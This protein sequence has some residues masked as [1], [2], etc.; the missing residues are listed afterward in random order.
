MSQ[1]CAS[2]TVASGQKCSICSVGPAVLT[3]P[4]GLTWCQK[5]LDR[6][7]PPVGALNA[8][9]GPSAPSETTKADKEALDHIRAI[10]G[11]G[12]VEPYNLIL[13]LFMHSPHLGDHEAIATLLKPL[14]AHIRS[15]GQAYLTTHSPP[16]SSSSSSP[17]LP[18][19]PQSTAGPGLA[20]SFL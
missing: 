11:A 14:E 4:S 5:C 1:S 12:C 9:T 3:R 6:T 15:M 8:P 2:T 13:A 16:S 17:S 20:F 10:V 19:A 7:K 18:T